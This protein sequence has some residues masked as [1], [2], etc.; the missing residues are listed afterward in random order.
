M[1][2]PYR[3]TSARVCMCIKSYNYGCFNATGMYEMI[4]DEADDQLL[5]RIQT[6]GIRSGFPVSIDFRR[7]KDT[8]H[9]HRILVVPYKYKYAFRGDQLTQ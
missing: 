7:E 8:S 2:I 9:V 5:L 6:V 3:A 1:K 4:G